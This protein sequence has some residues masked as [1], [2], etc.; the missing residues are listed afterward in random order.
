MAF[1]YSTQQSP[2]SASK[3]KKIAIYGAGGLGREIACLIADIN[4]QSNVWELVGFYDDG[5]A[6]GPLIDDELPVLGGLED[7]N[8]I[9]TPLHLVIAISDPHIKAKLVASIT[10]AFIAYPVLIHPTCQAGNLKYVRIGKGTVVT[11]GVIMTTHIHLGDFVLV[12]LATTIGHDVRVGD[13]S[14]IMP[15]CSISGNVAVG[16]LTS[17]G[18]GA[19]I[20]QNITLGDETIVGAGAIVTKNF[21]AGSKLIG[22][23]AL[24]ILQP[25]S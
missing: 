24:N 7:I 17:V 16:R 3:R 22:V 4:L 19:R 12:N 13:F 15:S 10:S 14:S 11:A 18:T 21:G 1:F 2:A 8:S 9:T 6:K 23:P 5:K 25:E 20:L